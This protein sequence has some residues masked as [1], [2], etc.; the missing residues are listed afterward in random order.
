MGFWMSLWGS[1]KKISASLHEGHFSFSWKD[2]GRF[3]ILEY[4]R[5]TEPDRI[6]LRLGTTMTT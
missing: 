5:C 4:S 2:R 1:I 6:D 3:R